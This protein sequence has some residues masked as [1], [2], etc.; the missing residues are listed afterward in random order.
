MT[1]KEQGSNLTLGLTRSSLEGRRVFACKQCL[2]PGVYK[3]DIVIRD[4]FESIDARTKGG[5]PKLYDPMRDG[6]PVG[7]IC[8][9]C[10]AKRPSDDS[11]RELAGSFPLW[12]WNIALGFKWLLIRLFRA[13]YRVLG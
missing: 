13:K 10:G 8:P 6:Q 5:W 3:K 1:E 12:V 2:A 4:G 7:D 9:Q 11:Q